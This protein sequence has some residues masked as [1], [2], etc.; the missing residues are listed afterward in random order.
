MARR[1]A[2]RQRADQQAETRQRIVE[3]AV[4]LHERHGLSGTTITDIAGQAGVGRQTFYRHFPDTLTLSHACSG[5]YWERN[6][7]PD[8]ARWRAFADPRARFETAL[9]E[10]YAY[11]RRTETMIG[12]MLADASAEPVMRAYHAHWRLAADVVASAFRRRGR[13]ARLLRAAIGH[14]LVFSTWQSLV[15]RQGL[16]SRQAIEVAMRM[17][18]DAA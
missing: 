5:L 2:L 10:S 9:R 6:P 13:R 7:P 14:A 15:R 3:A 18:E 4:S 8:P 17:A 16:A 12:T 1:Y 11:H